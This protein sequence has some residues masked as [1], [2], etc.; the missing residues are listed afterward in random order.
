MFVQ[1]A[2]NPDG[3]AMNRDITGTKKGWDYNFDKPVLH[4]EGLVQTKRTML[5]TLITKSLMSDLYLMIHL[6][7]YQSLHICAIGLPNYEFFVT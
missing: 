7:S 3:L 2:V 6:F 4:I 1:I 5:Q